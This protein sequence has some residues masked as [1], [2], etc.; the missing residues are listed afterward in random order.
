MISCVIFVI[1][2]HYKSIGTGF[3]CNNSV[4]MSSPLISGKLEHIAV[5]H[6]V[7]YDKM[8]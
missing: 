3:E 6:Q 5:F 1:L 7:I 2:K 8:S 4:M